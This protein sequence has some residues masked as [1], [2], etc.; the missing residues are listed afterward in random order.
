MSSSFDAI[1]MLALGRNFTIGTL[2]NHIEDVVVPSKGCDL[3]LS[4]L[5]SLTDNYLMTFL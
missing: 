2:Y 1:K 4:S 5:T 3:L